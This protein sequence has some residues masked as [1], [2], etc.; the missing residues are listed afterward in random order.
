MSAFTVYVCV[1]THQ[2][3]CVG[4]PRSVGGP[5]RRRRSCSAPIVLRVCVV[6]M[7]AQRGFHGLPTHALH[8]GVD[9]DLLDGLDTFKTGRYDASSLNHR[10]LVINTVD[11]TDT[12]K[13]THGTSACGA[14]HV[15]CVS[16]CGGLPHPPGPGSTAHASVVRRRCS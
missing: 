7:L 16:V 8:K 11:K 12:W 9:T 2:Q 5:R 3:H 6:A 4:T 13:Q 15:P 10:K 1:Y 14:C